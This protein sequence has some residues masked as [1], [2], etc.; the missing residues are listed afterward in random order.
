M[1]IIFKHSHGMSGNGRVRMFVGDDFCKLS[2]FSF[3][4]ALNTFCSSCG[5]LIAFFKN[6]T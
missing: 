2:N 4:D 1:E 3:N 6:K 5:A